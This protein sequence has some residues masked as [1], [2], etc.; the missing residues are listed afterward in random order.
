MLLVLL[1]SLAAFAQK[2]ICKGVVSDS[3]GNLVI[4]AS[5][6]QKGTSNGSITDA[7]GQFIISV[8][9]NAVLVFN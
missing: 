4:G 7:D 5:V 3:D 1:M 9:P 6:I 2:T 8:D